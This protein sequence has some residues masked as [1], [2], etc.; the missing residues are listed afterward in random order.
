MHSWNTSFQDLPDECLL[1]RNVRFEKS[2]QNLG[3]QEKADFTQEIIMMIMMA[4]SR[5]QELLG[6]LM[7]NSC[8]FIG[9]L[10]H[11][12]NF[13]PVTEFHLLRTLP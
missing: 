12:N 10:G 4:H 9:Q 13:L 6:R 5:K 7:V 8:T 3:M 1:T 2:S 11:L